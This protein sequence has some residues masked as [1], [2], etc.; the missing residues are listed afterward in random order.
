[1][2][3]KRFK[4]A[5]HL[6]WMALITL[7]IVLSSHALIVQAKPQSPAMMPMVI[8]Q[9]FNVSCVS[10]P[11]ISPTYSKLADLATFTVES[12]ASAVEVTFNGRIF[13][14]S[15]SAGTGAVFELRV[16]DAESPVGR[17]R[18]NLRTAE[19]GAGG[20]QT[21]ITGF[22]TGLA[23]G[24]HTASM[25]VRTSTGGAGNQAMVDP[26]CW[27]SDVLIVK[28]HIPFGTTYMPSVTNQ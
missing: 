10:V 16:D 20:V 3:Q 27:S 22:F 1:M 17:A 7:V 19:A 11:A 4:Q 21:S 8:P 24:T 15:F 13:V 2:F 28:E 6:P 12:S 18:A 9:V 25:W 5:N 23:A 14:S 26:G